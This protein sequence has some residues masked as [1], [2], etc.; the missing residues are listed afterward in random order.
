MSDPLCKMNYHFLVRYSTVVKLLIAQSEIFGLWTFV[1][2]NQLK[3]VKL[4]LA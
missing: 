3:I 2:K 1:N 4:M